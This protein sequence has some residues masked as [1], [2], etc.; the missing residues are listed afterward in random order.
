MNLPART[1]TALAWLLWLAT[2]GCCAAG[3]LVTLA[4]TRPLTLAV[5]ARGAAYA[6]AFPLG[7]A[8]IGLVLSL[9]R[10]AHPIGW[11][12]AAAGLVW[13]LSFPLEPWVT[14][15]A[16]D[17]RP[18]PLAAQLGF[19][20]LQTAWALAITCGI[21]LPLAAAA[22]RAAALPPLAPRGGGCRGRWGGRG[23]GRQP[24]AGASRG[25]AV[26]QPAG[27]GRRGR[28][29]RG[30]GQLGRRGGPHGRPGGRA[31]L[32]GAAV[33]RRPWGPAAA[34]ALGRRRRLCHGRDHLGTGPGGSVRGCAC[35]PGRALSPGVAV[36][37][38]RGRGGDAALPPLG[39]GPPGEPHRQLRGRH[40]PAGRPLPAHPPSRHP[41]GRRRRRSGGGR[42]H[43]GGGG[44]V[45]PAAPPGPAPGRP[46]L[47]PPSLR[48][49]P[50]RTVAGFA[51]RLREQV[52]LDALSTEL[53]AVVDQ[54]VQPS[55]TSLWLRPPATPQPQPGP[56]AGADAAMAQPG[57]PR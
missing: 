25:G 9:R 11:L 3:L 31:G 15:L 54:T 32:C 30:R 42:R 24:D 33:P 41:P 4:V 43:L 22:G 53:L 29:G 20:I 44:R 40:R 28:Q 14:Q 23:G 51:A 46:A 39:P 55:R 2:F 16:R 49:R 45:R 12:Y 19:V 7:Y 26:P 57:A 10:P 38:G 27:A 50:H 56:S 36:R 52:D 8:T 1:R 48:R 5:L 37:T 6:V 13:S 21:T 34:A 47:Q 35:R 18:L 17:R